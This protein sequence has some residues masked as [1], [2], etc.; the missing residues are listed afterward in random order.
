[1]MMMVVRMMIAIMM[2]AMLMMKYGF[3]WSSYQ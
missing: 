1:M 2:M 3:L